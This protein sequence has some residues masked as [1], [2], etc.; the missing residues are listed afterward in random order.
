MDSKRP[1]HTE[2]E[3]W[4]RVLAFS[5]SE[6]SQAEHEPCEGAKVCLKVSIFFRVHTMS[7]KDTNLGGRALDTPPPTLL[8]KSNIISQETDFRTEL[9]A[10]QVSAFT[11]Q[12]CHYF[13]NITVAS[14]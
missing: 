4:K 14:E 6:G 10:C 9:L 3:S 11:L 2:N 5:C 8:H 13:I 12:L 7:P 1:G